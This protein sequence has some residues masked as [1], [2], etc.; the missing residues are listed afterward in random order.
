MTVNHTPDSELVAELVEVMLDFYKHEKSRA[1]TVHKVLRMYGYNLTKIVIEGT[2][3][4][5]DGDIR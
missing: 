4:W 1:H 5:T 2:E 3:F